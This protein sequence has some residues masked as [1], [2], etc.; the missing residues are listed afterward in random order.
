MSDIQRYG[1][2]DGMVLTDEEGEFVLY[3]DHLAIVEK[4]KAELL[5]EYE[6]GFF[7]GSCASYEHY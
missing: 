1:Q 5:E 6:R 3:E 2:Y 7:N 4:L